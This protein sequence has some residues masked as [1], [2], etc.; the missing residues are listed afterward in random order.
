L[1]NGLSSAPRCFT[2][3]LKPVY[4]TLRRTGHDNVG[5]IDD[6]YLQGDTKD[7]C[8][9]NVSDTVA[10]L[11]KL[12][13]LIHPDKS[14]LVPVQMITFLGFI[15]DSIQMLV[16]PT[17]EKAQ[18]LKTTCEKL[19]T[20][21]E[22]TVE[23]LAE[24]I[25]IIVSNFPGVEFGPL[26]YRGLER[27]KNCALKQSKGNFSS[28]L[29]LSSA[30]I[31][32]L[33]WWRENIESAINHVTHGNPDIIIT[34]DASTLGWGAVLKNQSIGGQWTE[35]EA[36]HHINYLELL[37]TFLALKRFCKNASKVHV[38]LRS[39]N[40]TTVAYLNSMG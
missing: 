18:K 1:P 22:V 34:T 7:E 39:D 35:A 14:V 21:P 8:L 27:D 29:Q 23:E 13:F 30:A 16:R 19:L 31:T 15:L 38:R 25:G 11:T 2:K 3:I 4:V 40:T 36:C 9:S 12:G 26:F 17:L 32:E 33:N 37:A 28:K 20:K 6:Q 24:A 10:L 5:Y